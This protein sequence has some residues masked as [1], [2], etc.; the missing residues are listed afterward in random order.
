MVEG[1]SMPMDF[2]MNAQTRL[3]ARARKMAQTAFHLKL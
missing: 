1:N 2:L 3:H